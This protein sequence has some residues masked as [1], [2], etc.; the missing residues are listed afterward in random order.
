MAVGGLSAYAIHLR[1]VDD[2]ANVA[3]DPPTW[4]NGQARVE[5]GVAQPYNAPVT[6]ES[7]EKVATTTT[8]PERTIPETQGYA[9]RPFY[10]P[11]VLEVESFFNEARRRDNAGEASGDYIS[12]KKSANELLADICE[13][14]YHDEPEAAASIMGTSEFRYAFDGATLPLIYVHRE[15]KTLTL[16]TDTDG[17]LRALYGQ[18]GGA[19]RVGDSILIGSDGGVEYIPAEPATPY[20]YNPSYPG[21]YPG[22]NPAYN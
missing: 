6:E 19:S 20:P 18:Y 13:K 8:Q 22:Y 12:G 14:L 15:G 4:V 11:P 1:A 7:S 5:T 2:V 9:Q 17:V 10:T 3:Q 16:Y 21:Y